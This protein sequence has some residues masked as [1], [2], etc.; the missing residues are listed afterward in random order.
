MLRTDAVTVFKQWVQLWVPR[1]HCKTSVLK[2][3]LDSLRLTGTDFA[4][5][6]KFERLPFENAWSYRIRNYSLE[7]TFKR[8]DIPA[9]FYENLRI[10]SKIISGGHVDG[11][12]NG[13]VV[14]LA[15]LLFL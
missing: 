10:G 9:E 6:R 4:T 5:P 8:Y 14:S 15:A 11:Q 1:L 12:K 2:L 3:T 13:L 7:V